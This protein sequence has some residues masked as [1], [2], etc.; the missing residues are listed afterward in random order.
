MHASLF[1]VFTRC[2][3]MSAVTRRR[4]LHYV[5]SGQTEKRTRVYSN[6]AI[7]RL[8]QR[9]RS[10][11]AFREEN[12]DDRSARSVRR[13]VNNSAIRPDD[14]KRFLEAQ[15]GERHFA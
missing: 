1:N 3:P 12:R 11:R 14:V 5:W 13:A 15:F 9:R 6:T 8:T 2:A 4:W 10:L 7:R